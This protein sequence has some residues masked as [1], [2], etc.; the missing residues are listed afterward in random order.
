MNLLRSLPYFLLAVLLTVVAPVFGEDDQGYLDRPPVFI[1]N[2]YDFPLT[3]MGL[4]V[5]EG[6]LGLPDIDITSLASDGF[7]KDGTN[8]QPGL[9]VKTT[10]TRVSALYGLHN[11]WAGGISLPYERT[12]VRGEIGGFPATST[13][14]TLGD[15]ALLG[16]KLLWNDNNGNTL[17]ATAGIELPTGKDDAIF[18]QANPATNGYYSGSTQRLPISWQ[19]GSGSFDGYLALSYGR[20]G[21]RLSYV[22]LVATKLHSSGFDDSKI[23]DIFIGSING[24]YGI[25]R[26]MA[27]ALGLVVRSQQD[28]SYPNAPAPGVE[29]PLLAGTTEHG[30]TLYLN[31]SIRAKVFGRLVVG[32][33]VNYPL[34]KPDDGLVPKTN[35]FLI[36]YPSL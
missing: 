5:P 10:T 13:P 1:D 22:A 8:V 2:Q 15:I 4:Y 12:K 7:R 18:D 29:S 33:G 20:A 26:N 36:F 9:D 16:K 30:T 14:S 35:A 31:P 3:G 34:I 19:P 6:G 23:G 17:V 21:H 25:G 28:D 11:G 24:T 32:V 27:A